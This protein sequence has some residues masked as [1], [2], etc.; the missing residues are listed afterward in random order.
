MFVWIISS[1]GW[2]TSPEYRYIALPMK[3]RHFASQM[4]YWPAS[5]VVKHIKSHIC[6]IKGVLPLWKWWEQRALGANTEVRLSQFKNS[7]VLKDYHISCGCILP[8]LSST[9]QIR[10]AVPLTKC[11]KLIQVKSLLLEVDRKI[12]L[13]STLSLIFFSFVSH[14]S[15]S[16]CFKKSK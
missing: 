10:G 6:Y 13:P 2:K 5:S 7:V 9:L 11:R 3:K 4:V 15:M 1:S 8:P 12:W 16:H 14:V